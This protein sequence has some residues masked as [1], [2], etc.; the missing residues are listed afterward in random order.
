MEFTQLAR[1]ICKIGSQITSGEQAN[2]NT[3][4]QPQA[5]SVCM[6]EIMV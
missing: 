4:E 1:A 5:P 6:C 3:L 2:K